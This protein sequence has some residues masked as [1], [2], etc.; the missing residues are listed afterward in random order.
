MIGW[1]MIRRSYD[2]PTNKNY[3]CRWPR[4]KYCMYLPTWH[5]GNSLFD[6][7]QYFIRCIFAQ[8]LEKIQGTL[9]KLV[10]KFTGARVFFQI[11]EEKNKILD[12]TQEQLK[13]F[14][15]QFSDSLDWHYTFFDIVSFSKKKLHSFK[16]FIGQSLDT[17]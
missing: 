10:K 6:G 3:V 14:L 16:V 13:L 12:G 8:S 11:C 9:K 1:N 7:S 17:I 2:S 15:C 4:L 5:T